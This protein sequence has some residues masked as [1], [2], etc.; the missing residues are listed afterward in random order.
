LRTDAF[1]YYA[2]LSADALHQAA[3]DALTRARQAAK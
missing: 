2:H 1:A 3:S